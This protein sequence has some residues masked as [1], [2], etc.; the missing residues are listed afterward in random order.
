MRKCMPRGLVTKDQ[1]VCK[2]LK[3]KNKI[4]SHPHLSEQMKHGYD[5]ALNDLLEFL[6]EYR[7]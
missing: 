6:K 7:L 1:I 2:I 3:M 5:L 4:E